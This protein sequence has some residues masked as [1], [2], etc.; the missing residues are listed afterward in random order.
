MS[1]RDCHPSG[2]VPECKQQLDGVGVEVWLAGAPDR[3]FMDYD[4]GFLDR[5]TRLAHQNKVAAVGKN[6]FAPKV[7]PM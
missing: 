1:I 4:L 3:S 5:T 7:L 6:L 2:L